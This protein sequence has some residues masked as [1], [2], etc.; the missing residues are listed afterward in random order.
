MM[1]YNNTKVKVC[2]P[3]GD[4]DYFD[5]VAG[6]MQGDTLAPYLFIIYLD[7]ELRTSLA[8][9]KENGFNLAKER[10]RRYSAQTNA[11]ADCADDIVLLVNSPAQTDSQLHCLE[12]IACGIG[13]HVNSDKAEY[14]HVRRKQ[15]LINRERQ[16]LV[17]SKGVDSYWYAIGHIESRPGW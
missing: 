6:E 5:I 1:L 17:T 4:T 16:Q 7:F 9:M 10:S 11:D 15:C 8:L 3:D 13:L 2:S 14:V 12:R